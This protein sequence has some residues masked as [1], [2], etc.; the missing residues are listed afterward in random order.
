LALDGQPVAF[1]PFRP[2]FH[3]TLNYTRIPVSHDGISYA[4]DFDALV[5]G[6]LGLTPSAG[7]YFAEAA[8]YCLHVN[9]HKSNP[10]RLC[11]SGDQTGSG[12][13]FWGKVSEAHR[14][15]YADLQEAAEFGACAIAIILAVQLTGIGGVER[16]RASP[17]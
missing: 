12:S 3:R 8:W 2:P 16:L 9:Q 11:L 4:L 1:M 7:S 17:G 5:N 15:T 13:L 14:K 6:E 10:L